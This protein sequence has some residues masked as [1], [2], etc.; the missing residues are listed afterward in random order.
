[1]SLGCSGTVLPVCGCRPG[2]T[3]VETCAFIHHLD[4][5]LTAG[6]VFMSRFML[7]RRRRKSTPN[8]IGLPFC[9]KWNALPAAPLFTTKVL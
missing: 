3:D 4:S 1:M 9:P 2:N 5:V 6:M 8:C 7:Y